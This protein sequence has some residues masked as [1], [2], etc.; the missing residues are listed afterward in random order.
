MFLLSACAPAPEV[1]DEPVPE[2]M[3]EPEVMQ[4]KPAEP[5]E[6]ESG[7]AD[8]LP[9]LADFPAGWR[10][11]VDEPTS[12]FSEPTRTQEEA[13]VLAQ[14]RGFKEG[15]DRVFV[16]GGEVV[17]DFSNLEKVGIRAILYSNDHVAE[18]LDVGR[19]AVSAGEMELVYP[20][21][22]RFTLT[23]DPLN[24]PSIGTESI[25]MRQT[26]E[27]FITIILEFVENNVYVFMNCLAFDAAGKF[28]DARA[29]SLCV[30]YAQFVEGSIS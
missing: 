2:V 29:Q 16:T 4:E 10:I 7:S 30:Q 19:E 22:E 27:G 3:D 9:T 6:I 13:K 1:V 14:Q 8:L 26:D 25:L 17:G 18:G 28:D 23:V 24:D 12:E 5:Q 15:H 20:D 11:T 21:G